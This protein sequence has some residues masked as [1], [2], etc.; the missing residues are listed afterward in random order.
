MVGSRV[1]VRRTEKTLLGPSGG[2]IP[3]GAILV[4]LL[5]FSLNKTPFLNQLMVG[6]GIP[7]AWQ[8]NAMTCNSLTVGVDPTPGIII[9]GT[10]GVG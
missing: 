5:K 3:G 7:V 6:A 1:R 9:T 10:T 4:R 2:V 8:V